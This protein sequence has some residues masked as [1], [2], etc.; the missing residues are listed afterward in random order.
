VRGD[1]LIDRVFSI[2][3]QAR[4]NVVS[5][6]NSNMVIAQDCSGA[7]VRQEIKR[8]VNEVTRWNHLLNSRHPD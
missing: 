5:A 4:A 2:L 3:A 7:S 8:D 6:V 1:D